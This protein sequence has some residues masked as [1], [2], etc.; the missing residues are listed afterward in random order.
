[1]SAEI[2]INTPII[3]LDDRINLTPFSDNSSHHQ[4]EQI[5]EDVNHYQEE[6]VDVN[7]HQD[8]TIV[9]EGKPTEEML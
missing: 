8:E 3:L 6:T 4:E 1:M 9:A 2:D 5:L 7:H